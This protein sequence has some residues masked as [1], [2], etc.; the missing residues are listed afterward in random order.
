MS[1]V[2]YLALSWLVAVTNDPV[3][4]PATNWQER[5]VYDTVRAN[6]TSS[7]RFEHVTMQFLTANDTLYTFYRS[8]HA[9]GTDEINIRCGPDGSNVIARK[10]DFTPEGKRLSEGRIWVEDGK[11]HAAQI[12]DGKTKKVR[13]HATDGKLVAADASMLALLRFFPFDKGNVRRIQ[14]ATFDRY[15][16]TMELKQLGTEAIKV[17]AGTF[18]CYKLEGIVDLY[19]TSIRTVYWINKSEP[20]FLVKYEGKRGIFLAP[21]YVTSL[22]ATGD[23]AGTNATAPTT[24]SR[25]GAGR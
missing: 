18:E 11:V 5:Y 3:A 21:T 15:F 9:N 10:R 22:T 19:V 1:S 8:K 13:S 16:V 7:N 24:N 17:P 2:A 20:H 12:V 6:D 25:T 23:P 14:I 4:P